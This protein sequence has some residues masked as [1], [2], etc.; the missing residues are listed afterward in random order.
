MWCT[1]NVLLSHLV[2]GKEIRGRIELLCTS[3]VGLFT[4]FIDWLIILINLA[5]GA[6][7]RCLIDFLLYVLDAIGANFHTVMVWSI[8]RYHGQK[9]G[10]H[11][12]RLGTLYNFSSF[13]Y[14]C[15]KLALLGELAG[16]GS[17]AL[18]IPNKLAI[19]TSSTVMLYTWIV[20]KLSQVVLSPLL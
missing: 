8:C 1:Y 9:S 13:V 7:L 5:H 6:A 10:F 12:G 17:F 19:V 18:R 11:T 15:Q 3:I 4:I 20:I 16:P 2:F 14:A